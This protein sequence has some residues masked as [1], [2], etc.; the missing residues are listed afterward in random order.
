M[1]TDDALGLFFR[2][3]GFLLH[4]KKNQIIFLLYK[5]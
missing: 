4:K 2:L 5:C 3:Y 1:L